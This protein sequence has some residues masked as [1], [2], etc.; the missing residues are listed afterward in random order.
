MQISLFFLWLLHFLPLP[1]INRLGMVLGNLAYILASQRRQVTLTNL[2]LCFP[3]WR[4]EDCQLVAK[5]HFQAF[6]THILSQGMAWFTPLDKMKQIVRYE[7]F[8]YLEEAL[9]EGPVIILA[10]HF[11]GMDTGGICLAADVNLLS[12][13]ARHKNL[14]IDQQIQRHRLRW[15]RGKMF[16][17]QDGIRPIVRDLKTGWAFYY[18]P[19]LD[20]GP[21]ESIFVDFFTQ[22]AATVPALSRLSKLSK[23]KVIPS[24]AHQDYANGH[25]TIRFYPAWDHYPSDDIKLDTRRMNAFIEERVLE[26]PELYLWSH[27]RFKTRPAGV[28]S[29][30]K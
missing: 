22:Q 24:Y 4:Q 19:D 18:H 5:R 9:K 10:P 23:A 25:L 14:K 12:L 2:A 28:A 13:Y 1:W 3:Q 6:A 20:F 7:H 27:K 21:K 17:R 30:Y 26:K 11:F 8:E 16:S 29:P 15:G